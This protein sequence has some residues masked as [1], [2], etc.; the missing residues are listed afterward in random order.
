MHMTRQQ[1]IAWPLLLAAAAGVAAC[2]SEPEDPCYFTE[3]GECLSHVE[4]VWCQ[5]W[6]ADLADLQR[7]CWLERAEMKCAEP[8]MTGISVVACYERPRLDGARDLIRAWA[9][10]PSRLVEREGLRHCSAELWGEVGLWP[11]C[12]A[13]P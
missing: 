13:A 9:P 2:T 1:M 11:S 8:D 7:E 4:R 10:F 3:E 6:S 12:P 5:A